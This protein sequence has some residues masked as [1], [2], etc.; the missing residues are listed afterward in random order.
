M[1]RVAV[2]MLV[3]ACGRVRFEPTD[4][5]DGATGGGDAVNACTTW[6]AWSTP[7]ALAGSSSP[8]TDWAP[9]IS[10]SGLRLTFSSNRSGNQELYVVTRTSTLSLAWTDPV[11]I[12][13]LTNMF[14]EEDDP[15]TSTDDLEMI[16]GKTQ[17]LRTRRTS[18]SSMWGTRDLLVPGDFDLVQGSELSSDDL[19]LYFSA[20]SPTLDLYMMERAT[21]TSAFGPY[22][23]IMPDPDPGGDTG[24]PTLSADELEMFVSSEHA[25]QRDIYTS[26]RTD[27]SAPFPQMTAV[28][29]V[30]S[31]FDDWDP[32]LSRDGTE[33]FLSS[34]R[35]PSLG[36]QDL[37]VATRACAD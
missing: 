17:I 26:V 2:W 13:E 10:A 12:S 16:F 20:G 7:V 35:M 24:Y 29:A 18:T 36:A 4:T 23:L 6:G 28:P 15:T 11:A 32:E 8:V 34:G 21:P 25:G 37:W 9:S 22:A 14:D 31:A 27:R 33:L 19:R 3:C 5:A 1:W 30:S